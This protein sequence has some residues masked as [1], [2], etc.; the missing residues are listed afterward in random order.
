VQSDDDDPVDDQEHDEGELVSEEEHA[1]S[2]PTLFSKRA[3]IEDIHPPS[4]PAQGGTTTKRLK[5]N[6]HSNDASFI[7][8]G[9]FLPFKWSDFAPAQVDSEETTIVETDKTL[10]TKV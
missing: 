6:E 8:N 10:S 4:Q 2:Q 5:M 1:D 7:S 3:Y 9:T